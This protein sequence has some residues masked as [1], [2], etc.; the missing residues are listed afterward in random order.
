MSYEFKLIRRVEFC[1]TDMAGIVHY[2]NFF[3]YMESAEHAFYRSLGFSVTLAKEGGI[4]GLPRVHAAC[5][6][7]APLR[8]EDEFE[9][10]L[11][12]R[13]KR[14]KTLTYDFIFRKGE[15]LVAQGALTI[16]CV[17][18]DPATKSM[19]SV[20]LPSLMADKIQVA[21]PGLLP[22]KK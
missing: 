3:R 1:E 10:H 18:F 22:E 19:K 8:C 4:K 21:P 2:S 13:E 11:I 5:D 20:P 9:I 17:E 16:V 6:Y 14:S 15:T 12:V 7:R